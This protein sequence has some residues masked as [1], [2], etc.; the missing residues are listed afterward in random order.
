M[1]VRHF[2]LDDRHGPTDASGT[3][4]EANAPRGERD[5]WR[6]GETAVLRYVWS[7]KVWAALPV[8][9]VE[10]SLAR[11]A[12]Y[13]APGTIFMGP[14]CSR[15]EHLRVL[16]SGT[17]GLAQMTWND[18]PMLW[19]SV[20]GEAYSIWTMWQ[21]PGWWHLGWKVNP[22]AP[23][24]RTPLGFDTADYTLD[25]VIDPDL[26]RWSWK[27]EDEFA[28]AI[29]LG[30]LTSTQATVIREGTLEVVERLLMAGRH[31]MAA[32]AAWRPPTEWAT[33]SLPRGWDIV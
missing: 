18:Q 33:P 9:I 24:R 12:L 4:D 31:E 5:A 3:S 11:R 32:W 8:T 19:T 13:M 26:E 17:W 21:A 1:G 30:L 16:A 20:P 6:P 15:A 7:G 14:D 27:D 22:E 2:V 10:D 29:K 23:L 25:A 28:E